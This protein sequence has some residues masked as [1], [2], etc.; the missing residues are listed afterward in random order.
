MKISHVV[1]SQYWRDRNG[2]ATEFS[3]PHCK[4]KHTADMV[5]EGNNGVYYG[6]FQCYTGDWTIAWFG[7]ESHPLCPHRDCTT[8]NGTNKEVLFQFPQPCSVCNVKEHPLEVMEEWFRQN[9]GGI[10]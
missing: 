10:Y 6:Q 7:F 3:C 1:A 9:V 5:R 4:E 8:C 2:L